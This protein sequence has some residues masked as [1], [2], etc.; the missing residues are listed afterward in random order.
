MA[1][2]SVAGGVAAPFCGR[3]AEP[4]FAAFREAFTGAFFAAVFLAA[5]FLTTVG[6]SVF[7]AAWNA[8]QRFLV[9]STMAR[10]PAALSFRFGF[11]GSGAAGGGGFFGLAHRFPW[12]AT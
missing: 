9:A 6:V 12:G 10:L 1:G 4:F 7:F 3:L 11:G 2:Y 8:A 5:R